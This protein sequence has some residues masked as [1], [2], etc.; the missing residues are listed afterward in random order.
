MIHW[1]VVGARITV[2][3]GFS[4]CHHGPK[5]SA[6]QSFT[7]SVVIPWSA[8]HLVLFVIVDSQLENLLWAGA[9]CVGRNVSSLVDIYC[10]PVG[11]KACVWVIEAHMTIF[12][13]GLQMSYNMVGHMNIPYGNIVVLD[14]CGLHMT[15]LLR[16]T[17]LESNILILIYSWNLRSK[18]LNFNLQF[19]PQCGPVSGGTSVTI[20]GQNFGNGS[21]LTEGVSAS[22]KVAMVDCSIE[23]R[24][25]TW[26]VIL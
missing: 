16:V 10:G 13:Y 26:S 19:H 21:R 15:L 9:T 22:V 25:D 5:I 3:Q 23:H 2:Q 7:R 11:G 18:M 4:A 14:S 12:L 6:F 8:S 1:D 17:D 20:V 24:N